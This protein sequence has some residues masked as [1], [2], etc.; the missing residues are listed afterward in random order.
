MAIHN[1]IKKTRASTG[2]RIVTL[3]S[4]DNTARVNQLENRISDQE[5]KLD[6]ILELLKNGN[7]L[8]ST[9]Q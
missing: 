3:G 7:N 6:Q 5:K 9:N 1:L 8:P 2:Q 4:P